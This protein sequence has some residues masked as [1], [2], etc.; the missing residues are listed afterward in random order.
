[1]G[2]LLLANACLCLVVASKLGPILQ[3]RFELA[4]PADGVLSFRDAAFFASHGM[5]LYTGMSYHAP[6]VVFA[7][8]YSLITIANALGALPR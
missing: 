6:P 3:Q 4:S 8:C 7:A 2:P 5:S 1:M